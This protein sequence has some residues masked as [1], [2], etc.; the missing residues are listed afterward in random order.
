MFFDQDQIADLN[1]GLREMR[2]AFAAFRL[3]LVQTP[4]RAAGAREHADHGFGRRLAMTAHCI[5]QVYVLLPPD[6]PGLPTRLDT[7]SATAHIQA[8]VMNIF[9]CCENVAWIWVNERQPLMP[10]GQPWRPV[11]VG[12]LPTQTELRATLPADSRPNCGSDRNCH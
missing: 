3:R 10:N 4:L 12:L 7:L 11:R 8:F 1:A 6:Q 2:D 9:G 5:E